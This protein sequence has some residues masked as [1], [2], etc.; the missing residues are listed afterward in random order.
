MAAEL[1]AQDP[2]VGKRVGLTAAECE[3]AAL[4]AT[5][6]PGSIG[7]PV[8]GVV[9][10][11]M[12]WVPAG[13]G[14]PA[15]CRLAGRLLPVDTSST[16]PPIR[17]ALALPEAWNR[18]AIQV[19]GGGM[20]G[21]VPRLTGIVAGPF[22][23]PS[24]LQQ[25]FATYGSDS[26]HGND[27]SWLLN[28]EAIRNLGHAQMKKTHD[29]AMVLIGRAYG[30][31]PTFNYY[32]GGSQGGREALT[33]AQ[34]YPEDY[35]GVL[36]TV[37]IVGFSTLM[38]APSLT[39]IQEKQ[40]EHWV[41]PTKGQA[42]L[43]E[44]MRQ[45]DDLDGQVDGVI[46]NY[47]D[48]RAL[49]NVN[50][51][52]REPDPWAKLRCPGNADPNPQNASIGDCLTAEQIETVNFVFSTYMSPAN[53]ANGRE[54]FGMWAPSTAVAGAGGFGPPPGS[55]APGR[56]AP[57]RAM[58]PPG[59]LFVAERYRGQEGAADDAPIFS[60]L[61][62]EG[63]NG[64]TMQ[65]LSANP[66]D[67]DVEK[68]RARHEQISPWLDS[69]DPDLS[70]FR[71]SGGRLIVVVGTDDLVAPSGEQLDYYQSV[72][73][74]MGRSA[75]DEFARFYVLPQTGHSLSGFSASVDGRG[76]ALQPAP[77]PNGI[78]RFALLRNWVE[79]GEA[80]GRSEVVT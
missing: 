56:G 71:K 62:S 31:R 4:A 7:E 79:R 12:T 13:Q 46:N 73:D 27:P 38:L 39:R 35:D 33:V 74:T 9:L 26:G 17:F 48:C 54:T 65:E 10:D 76:A 14:G 80:P 59:A 45:C 52:G 63:V 64:I 70:G 58:A 51:G 67:Y 69:T 53:L 32:V 47:A 55:G 3:S 19:G 2:D 30:E 66:L 28:D 11:S 6:P 16:A 43:A 15:H 61:G 5:V 36:A 25:G 20:N 18:R 22:G 24:D 42:I 68:H 72:L 50:D 41:P 44:F 34:R 78:D 40:L 21:R 23:G 75:V 57:V 8:S 1:W 77:I 49:F 60:T 37:P 29:V